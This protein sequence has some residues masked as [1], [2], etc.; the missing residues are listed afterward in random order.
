MEVAICST[1]NRAHLD[2]D[3]TP[4]GHLLETHVVDYLRRLEIGSVW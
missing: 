4:K 2:K 3:G 1:V